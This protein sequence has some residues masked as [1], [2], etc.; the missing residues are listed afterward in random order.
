MDVYQNALVGEK[1]CMFNYS[2]RYYTVDRLN[3]TNCKFWHPGHCLS[4]KCHTQNFWNNKPNISWNITWHHMRYYNGIKFFR[5]Y[6]Q[7]S[8][9]RRAPEKY[10]TGDDRR[11]AQG[12]ISEISTG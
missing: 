6:G 1:N 7:Y 8:Q 2:M 5:L 11:Q 3:P 4:N 12:G 10:Y 9:T